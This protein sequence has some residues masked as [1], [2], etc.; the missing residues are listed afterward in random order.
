MR[1]LKLVLIALILSSIT[2]PSISCGS[3][4]DEETVLENQVVTVQ[5]GD[6]TLDI[7]AAGNLALSYTAEPAFKVAGY[8][9]EVLVEEGD[10]V[11]EGQVLASLDT[12]SLER[13]V[14]TAEQTAKTTEIDLETATDSYRKI[15]YPYTYRTI[16]LDVPAAVAIT[17]NAQ[18]ELDQAI[19]VMQE[20]GLSREQYDWKQYWE[21]W[22]NLRDTQ[23]YLVKVK[24]NLVR[25]TGPDV[26]Q[27]G[28][29]SMSDYWTLKSAQL[30]MEK[31]QV[32]L[33]K[34]Q[35]ALDI[36]KDELEKAVVVAPFA[37]FIT[38]VNVE[39]GDEVYKGTVVAQVAD[40]DKFEA[41][42]LV[43]EMDIFQVKLGGDATVQID[44]MSTLTLP[45][46][47]T[48]ISPTATITSGVVNYEVKVEVQSLEVVASAPPEGFTLPEGFTP[49][50]QVGPSTSQPAV[51][52]G[53]FQLR[54]GLTVTVSILVEERKDVL[55]VPNGA[56]TRRGMETLVQVSED[57]VTEER[58][59]TTG[60]SNWQYTEVIS[61]LSEGEQVVVPQGTTTTPTTPERGGPEMR[62]FAP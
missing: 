10:T 31:A 21:V 43:S 2:I 58:S 28:I 24:E 36:A 29:L 49:P 5:R 19:E 42:I 57:G 37:G 18:R 54:E 33:D 51:I 32:A 62:F 39:G 20:L 7:T 9:E 27:S 3:E 55:L 30:N 56:I 34:A 12:T 15:T 26:F 60:I 23:A 59:V 52:P 38:Q 44:A 1:I 53:D 13:A 61:G 16:T 46:K 4:S 22:Q 11:E 45:A 40:P 14:K 6:L 41:D 17:T 50:G 35:D 25:G 47:V 8:V 48:H